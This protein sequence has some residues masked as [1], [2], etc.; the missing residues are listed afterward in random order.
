MT[1]IKQIFREE[2]GFK[3]FLMSVMTFALAYGLYKGAPWLSC[4]YTYKSN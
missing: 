4:R 3:A 2:S 1:R